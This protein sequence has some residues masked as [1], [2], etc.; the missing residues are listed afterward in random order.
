MRMKDVDV[1]PVIVAAESGIWN[2]GQTGGQLVR[3]PLI[4]IY[5]P[6]P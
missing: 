1:A 2:M 5:V 3:A 4:L 6:S